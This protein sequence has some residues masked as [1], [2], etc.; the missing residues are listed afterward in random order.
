MSLRYTRSILPDAWETRTGLVAYSLGNFI[1]NMKIQYTDSGIILDFTIRETQEGGFTVDNV[2]CVPVFC[3][4]QDDMIQSLSSLK[5][6]D[7][8]PEGM[9][10][11]RY[12]RMRESYTELRQLIGEEIE[13]LAE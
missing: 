6:Y 11:A 5:Y 3:W 8:R 1:S 12:S 7:E 9:S 2:G 10:D 4:R 13:M